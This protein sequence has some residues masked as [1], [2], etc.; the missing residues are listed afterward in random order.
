M[1]R[2]VSLDT[3]LIHC[4]ATNVQGQVGSKKKFTL[5]LKVNLSPLVS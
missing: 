5:P 1:G 3:C 4:D 2:F